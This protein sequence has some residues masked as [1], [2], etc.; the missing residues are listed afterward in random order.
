M[1]TH[2]TLNHLTK[3]FRIRH[4]FN[5]RLPALGLLIA[6]P[7]AAQAQQ[8]T[9]NI[10][11]Q[12]L[13]S[14]LQALAQQTGA[15]VLYNSADADNLQTHA[16]SGRYGLGESVRQLLQGTGLNYQLD[17]NTVTVVR[18]NDGA[19]QLGPINVNT[20]GLG[21][22]T[23]GTGSYT[24]GSTNTATKMNLSLRETP[25]SVSVMT[26]QRIDDQKLNRLTDVLEQ[27]P[28]LNVT[29]SGMERFDIYSRGSAITNYQID[30]ITTI[31]ES[32]TRTIPQ[33]SM[34]MA[35][36]DRVEVLRG[37]SGL[38]VGSG[39]PGG[40]INLVRKRPTKDFQ[41]YVQAGAGSW[42]LYRT[43]ADV[44]GPL[45]EDGRIRGRL[46]GAKQTQNSFMDWYG[47]QRDILYGVV[48]TDLSDTTVLR[49]GIDYQKM[50]IDG[51]AGVPLIYSNGQ[52]AYYSRSTS[53]GARWAKD[54]IETYNYIVN[55]EQQLPYDWSLNVAANYMDIDRS[56]LIGNY[57]FKDV[58]TLPS[59]NQQ[60]GSARADRGKSSADQ[61]QK[62]LNVTLQGP[63]DLFNRTHQLVLGF[64]YGSY[65]NDHIAYSDGISNLF[66][67]NTWDNYLPRGTTF[68]PSF[69]MQTK[70]LQRGAFVANQFKVTDAVSVI[71]GART[72]DFS[73]D[74]NLT[75]FSSV[76]P[77]SSKKR[78]HG[79]VS[80]Y[81]AV[82][83]DLTPEQSVYVSYT[84][85]F[86]PQ[87]YQDRT[88]AVLEPVT[89]SNYEAG[90]KG[91]FLDGRLNAAV[92]VYRVERDNLAD[93]DTGYYVPGTT[94]Q[95][96][97]NIDGATTKGYDVE[98]TGQVAPGWNVTG[99]F[100]HSVTKDQDGDRA[101]TSLPAD[102]LKLWS[103]YKLRG[104]WDKLTVGGGLNW[105]GPTYAKFG[106]YKVGEGDYTVFNSMARYQVSK[107]L[108][109]TLNFNNIFDKNYLASVKGAQGLYGEP[110]NFMVNVRY[111]F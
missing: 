52:R 26:R 89:G 18:A 50:E 104:D 5:A 56:T 16:V 37:A 75:Y 66:N 87:S 79:Q 30:G 47:T 77:S 92:A 61:T 32:Q 59:L 48:E 41:A 46:V 97:K 96:Y 91:E 62:G 44:S 4:V 6:L 85:I 28:G 81:A 40:L 105:N 31:T 63:Y 108:A 29:Y 39:D 49:T 10:P 58:G 95:A 43:E 21:A 107:H 54:E 99:S 9:L 67:F 24:T 3:A 110:R 73:Y 25:Q 17:G 103:T 70:Y 100:T 55:L 76:A 20:T 78:E 22:T 36:Y 11:A 98:V 8:W 13:G 12:S 82:V 64:N 86:Q 14:A 23:E 102:M 111:D 93:V 101:M 1:P 90:W 2:Y 19:L 83:Y 34:D 60:T 53:V 74:Y 71:L 106:Q 94:T 109:T 80:P 51:A 72:S 45:T 88:G 68:T 7:L 69:T 27:T 15:Q 35:L 84:D 42:D 57:L 38:M 65:K 33:T